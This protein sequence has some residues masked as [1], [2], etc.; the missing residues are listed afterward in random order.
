M[1]KT[2]LTL[3][4]AASVLALSA[5]GNSGDEKVLTSKVGDVTKDQLYSELKSTAGEQALQLMMIEKV[6]EDKYKVTDKEVKA[7]FDEQK[8]QITAGGQDFKTALA[9]QGMN[10]DTFK[11]YTKLNLLQEKAQTDGV[12]VSDEEIK[13][14]YD[15]QKTSLKA[16]HILVAD[17]AAAKKIEK[18]LKEDPKKF[19]AIA[20]KESTDSATAAKGGE[21]GWF[22]PNEMVEEFTNAAYD[23]KKGEISKPIK[24]SFGYHIIKLEDTKKVDVKKSFEDSK[25]SIKNDLL[26]KKAKTDDPNGAKVQEKVAKL[27]K[28]AKIEIKDK[29]L[30]SALDSFLK[31][32][33]S[34]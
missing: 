19:A 33:E 15:R 21:L 22:G 14:N 3:T 17:E 6:L 26:V 18:Q 10:E 1:K 29:D 27:M 34:K 8:A 23:M 16:S 11:R 7:K 9:S 30:K 32:T 4:I 13:K 25:E 2:A 20:K 31:K 12:K 5:C 28:D 24:S